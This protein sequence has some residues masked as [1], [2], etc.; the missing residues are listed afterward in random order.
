MHEEKINLAANQTAALKDAFAGRDIRHIMLAGCG[1]SLATLYPAKYIMERE[2]GKLDTAIYSSNEFFH[3][4]PARLGEQTLVILNSQSGAT[5]ETVSAARLAREKGALTAAFTTN[6]DSELA[7]VADHTILYFD[8]PQDPYP[9]LLTIFP[10]V[11]NAVFSLLDAAQGDSRAADMRTATAALQQILDAAS[12]QYAS[13]ARQ[14][15]ETYRDEKIIYTVGAGLDSAIAYVATNCLFMES[16][17][18]HSSPLHAGEFFH[19]AFEAVG[20][21]TPVLAFLGLGRTRPVEERAVRFLQRITE[22][23]TVLDAMSL[24]LSAI[25]AWTRP[26][27]APLALNKLAANCCDALSYALG[28]PI[29]SRRYMGVEK[30]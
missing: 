18:I 28:H 25:P 16:I 5:P 23:L 22:K 15:G 6:P 26:Y 10:T 11:Y 27:I 20:K 29:S 8:N 4:P 9:A 30:Y 21:D 17:W 3:D 1:G 12:A 14:F 2:S 7:G 13:R 24:D 19:G